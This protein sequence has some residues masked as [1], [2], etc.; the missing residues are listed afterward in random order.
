MENVGTC[1]GFGEEQ[2]LEVV[3]S[4]SPQDC[5]SL[6]GMSPQGSDGMIR[7]HGLD[8]QPPSQKKKKSN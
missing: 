1:R 7:V 8:K 3:C 5:L 4:A 6:Q 2:A